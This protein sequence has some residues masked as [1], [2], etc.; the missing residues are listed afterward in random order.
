M[1][2][3][4]RIPQ[5]LGDLGSSSLENRLGAA[6][7]L[8]CMVVESRR[9]GDKDD[10]KAAWRGLL[11][12]L[13]DPEGR[14]GRIAGLALD[15][16]S[17]GASAIRPLLAALEEGSADGRQWAARLLGC[18]RSKSDMFMPALRKALKDSSPEVRYEVRLAL[19]QLDGRWSPSPGSK[20]QD[21]FHEDV[22]SALAMSPKGDTLASGSYDGSVILWSFHTAKFIKRFRRRGD[23]ENT[24]SD[25]AF[26]RSGGQLAI[27][28]MQGVSVLDLKSGRTLATLDDYSSLIVYDSQRLETGRSGVRRIQ[29][30][31][32]RGQPVKTLRS[33]DPINELVSP[34]GSAL[35]AVRQEDWAIMDGNSG[36]ILWRLPKQVATCLL[37]GHG[38]VVAGIESGAD[39]LRVWNALTGEEW[40][41]IALPNLD[42]FGHSTFAISPNGK[43][44]AAG[45]ALIDVKSKKVRGNLPSPLWIR[46]IVFTQDSRT[47]ATAGDDHLITVRN[48][49]TGKVKR[50]LGRRKNAVETLATIPKGELVAS[51]YED[52]SVRLWQHETGRLVQT[53]KGGDPKVAA[54]AFSPDGERLAWAQGENGCQVWDVLGKRPSLELRPWDGAVRSLAWSPNG[55]SIA[56]GGWETHDGEKAAK[57]V[58]SDLRSGS[59][60]TLPLVQSK[61]LSDLVFGLSGSVLA[62]ISQ[63]KLVAWKTQPSLAEVA[64]PRLPDWVCSLAFSPDGALLACGMIGFEVIILETSAW[65]IVRTIRTRRD[66][67]G[68]IAFSPD[69]KSIVLAES[70]DNAFEIRDVA[71]GALTGILRGHRAAGRAVV[72]PEPEGRIITAAC[73]GTV[74]TWDGVTHRPLRTL[75]IPRS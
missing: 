44:L 58:I 11:R 19:D 12:A 66:T 36:R 33:K 37:L 40:E 62:G 55:N 25:V 17:L 34:P 18:F 48:A 30:L 9:S 22:I 15:E 38:E 13:K 57:G 7:E 42:F 39:R 16:R 23:A 56:L 71:T 63:G 47:V 27:V 31:N 28:D 64:V 10:L 4:P 69:G 43:T 32:G 8:N 74:R 73:D 1:T 3:N 14:I 59:T 70:Y 6:M 68:S 2:T 49:R 52:G 5:L 75:P 67:I 20:V 21:G 29:F 35:L 54:M 41:G 45:G 72:F 65:Q 61:D 50:I 51:G 24:V 26:S 60:L 46:A 53:I